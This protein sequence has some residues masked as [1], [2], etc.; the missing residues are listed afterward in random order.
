MTG[1]SH[2]RVGSNPGDSI[3]NLEPVRRASSRLCRGRFLER[4]ENSQEGNL[5]KVSRQV[6]GQKGLTF[7][8][9]APFRGGFITFLRLA[10]VF[11]IIS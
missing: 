6:L 3:V 2:E 4:T 7:P 1:E 10:L 9:I 11:Q 8:G 5:A